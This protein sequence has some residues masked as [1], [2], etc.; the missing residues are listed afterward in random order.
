M[1]IFTV[2][3][4]TL[5]ASF[6]AHAELQI[7]SVDELPERMKKNETNTNS[8]A[9]LAK[10]TTAP[11]Q[12]LEQFKSEFSYAREHS[13]LVASKP[14]LQSFTRNKILSLG[15][16]LADEISSGVEKENGKLNGVASIYNCGSVYAVTYEYEYA[17]KLKQKVTYYD[18]NYAK[19]TGPD[20][21]FIKERRTKQ[22][23]TERVAYT[24][25]NPQYEIQVGVYIDKTKP[26]QTIAPESFK[27]ALN[28]SIKLLANSTLKQTIPSMEK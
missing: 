12:T 8:R 22:T 3:F 9:S 28:Q 17:S 23:D 11:L 18:N 25:L 5:I 19:K 27:E 15:C 24:W 13:E 4:I 20:I 6:A 26:I 10:K 1:K 14:D 2:T 21:Y 16:E 7:K